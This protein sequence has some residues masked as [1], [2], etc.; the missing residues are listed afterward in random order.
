MKYRQ[1][2]FRHQKRE[3]PGGDDPTE[4]A[5]GQPESFPC[6]SLHPSIR[7][8]ETAGSQAAEPVIHHAYDGIWIHTLLIRMEKQILGEIS[9]P[10]YIP[11][12]AMRRAFLVFQQCVQFP[13][14]NDAPGRGNSKRS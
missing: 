12:L 6:P 9:T 5:A 7:H 8:I 13:P 1:Q 3:E 2:V 11:Y 14:R 4:E 10:E